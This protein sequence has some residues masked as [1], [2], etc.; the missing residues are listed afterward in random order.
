M[1]VTQLIV[2]CQVSGVL[3]LFSLSKNY[4]YV[5]LW[6]EMHVELKLIFITFSISQLCSF[7]STQRSAVACGSWIFWTNLLFA[8]NVP[9]NSLQQSKS[10][11]QLA[12]YI[13]LLPHNALQLHAG[14]GFFEPTYCLPSMSLI[15]HSNNQSQLIE[16][17]IHN[18]FI[19]S[20]WKNLI[21][22]V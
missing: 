14:L 20:Y 19:F 2:C 6:G 3:S 7:T 9:Y 10:N 16:I 8:I 5:M 12:S 22:C 15:I 13:P 1:C 17:L 21:N 11:F 18:R 4:A